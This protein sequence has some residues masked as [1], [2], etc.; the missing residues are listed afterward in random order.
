VVGVSVVW[1][2]I[3]IGA[4]ITRGRLTSLDFF[5]WL[6]GVYLLRFLIMRWSDQPASLGAARVDEEV[7]PRL[8]TALDILVALVVASLAYSLVTRPGVAQ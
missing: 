5:A 4:A 8:R 3:L 7:H 1:L 2:G 6:I